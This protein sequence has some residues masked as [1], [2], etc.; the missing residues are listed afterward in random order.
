MSVS[1]LLLFPFFISAVISVCIIFFVDSSTQSGRKRPERFLCLLNLCEKT[2]E[3]K[4]WW[5]TSLTERWR[6]LPHPSC[7][8]HFFFFVFTVEVYFSRLNR[9]QL[10]CNEAAN[11][12]TFV[13]GQQLPPQ[14]GQRRALQMEIVSGGEVDRNATLEK[15]TFCCFWTNGGWALDKSGWQ[16]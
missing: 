4:R 2:K 13:Q 7:C 15:L 12:L 10:C 3:R 16:K 1:R 14:W 6:L 9:V 8:F 5:G 11:V